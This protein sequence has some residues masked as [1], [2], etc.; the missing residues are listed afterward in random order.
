MECR[1]NFALKIKNFKSQR[2]KFLQCFFKNYQMN[3]FFLFQKV[4]KHTLT[5][6]YFLHGW[7]LEIPS[8]FWLPDFNPEEVL[9]LS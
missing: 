4:H 3:F 8:Y 2:E 6:N 7:A 1:W 5:Y 9:W